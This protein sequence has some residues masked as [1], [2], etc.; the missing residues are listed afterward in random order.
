MATTYQLW[1]DEKKGVLSTFPFGIF[2]WARLDERLEDSELWQEAQKK[3]PD[4]RD[5][6]LLTPKQPH[7]E[8]WNTELYG[9]GPNFTGL[10]AKR[11]RSYGSASAKDYFSKTTP[12]ATKA[13]SPCA[14]SS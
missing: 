4:G 7:V 11:A 12:S 5:P 9:G 8:Y 1:K 10:S 3:A 13:P 6:M 14:S 2:A